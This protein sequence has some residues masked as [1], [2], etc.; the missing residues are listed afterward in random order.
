MQKLLLNACKKTLI[1]AVVVI[2][3]HFILDYFFQILNYYSL[4]S[5]YAFHIIAALAVLAIIHLV[6]TKSKD[7]T[8][9]AFMGTSLLKMLAAVLFLLPGF[10][11]ENKPEFINIMNFFVPYFIFLVF[12]TLIVVKL[13]NQK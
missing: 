13:I 7:H 4:I 2:A 1:F 11:S 10:L 3:I 8:G 9:F 12:E 6:Y 5:I